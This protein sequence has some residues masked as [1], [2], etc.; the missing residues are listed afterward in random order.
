MA[1]FGVVLIAAII[2]LILLIVKFKVHPV[3]AIFTVGVL[4]GIA[5]GYGFVKTAQVFTGGFGSTLGSIGA[6]IIF[7]S[8]I[9]VSIQDSGAVK[10]IVNFFIRL[11][12]GKVLELAT[13]FTA[14]V[15]SI[16]IF[17]DVTQ[18]LMAPIAAIIAKRKK[19]SMST[20]ATWTTFAA[21]LTHSLI[22][23]TPG[24]LAVTIL[25]GAD[26]GLMIFWSIVVSIIAYLGT[27]AVMRK[28]VAKEW[29]EPR[30]DYS[31]GIEPAKSD[32]YKELLMIEPGLPSVGVS[33]LPILLPVIFIAG[34]SFAALWL[35]DGN[36]IRVFLAAVGERNIAMF[37]GALI[38][39]VMAFSMK[40]NVIKHYKINTGEDNK[41]ISDIVLN[42]WTNRALTI[43]LLPLLITA[44]G[45]G[46]SAIIRAYP[47]IALLGD[48]VAQYQFPTILVPWVIAAVM[49]IAVGS[50][51]T[52]GMTAA[53]IVLPMSGALGFNPLQLALIIGS[54]TLVG[55]HVSDSGFWVGTQLYNLNVK[56]GLKYLTLIQAVAGVISLIAIFVFIKLGII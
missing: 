29:I 41:N 39:I 6:T 20:M 7:G 27:Y 33:V 18:V 36:P 5:Y 13:G 24:I 3:L 50:R 52:A 46:F 32:D 4:A 16:P 30:A 23:P 45:G 42:K 9:A 15:M 19:T 48:L 47:D 49:M 11:F 21:S 31:A 28:W 44:M 10:S 55:T 25:L 54:G 22:P 1:H 17:G 34:A 56:Q 12:K 38:A 43:A 51:T 14:F 26:V 2:I 37:I 40:D 35:P 8:I 53:A